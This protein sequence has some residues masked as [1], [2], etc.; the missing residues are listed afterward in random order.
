MTETEKMQ[1]ALSEIDITFCAGDLIY[2]DNDSDS[3]RV[4]TDSVTH[5]KSSAG[6]INMIEIDEEHPG[7]F[8]V[9]DLT[10]DQAL[11]VAVMLS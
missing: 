1:A 6:N 2:S 7:Q 11:M 4:A 3:P 9:Y 5:I 8:N 10:Y